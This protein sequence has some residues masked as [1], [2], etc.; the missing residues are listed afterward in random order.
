MYALAFEKR[1]FYIWTKK[2]RKPIENSIYK[3]RKRG[4][5]NH[6]LL[7]SI[8]PLLIVSFIAYQ[9]IT[10]FTENDD[11]TDSESS[12]DVGFTDGRTTLVSYKEDAEYYGQAVDDGN[13]AGMQYAWENGTV[14]EEGT[15]VECGA[16]DDYHLYYVKVIEG[17]YKGESGYVHFMDITDIH[18]K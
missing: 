10:A 12:F 13:E 3:E 7:L 6:I 2:E 11:T 15:K 4:Q 9:S 1:Y 17:M 5:R 16:T 8:I 18:D 14:L